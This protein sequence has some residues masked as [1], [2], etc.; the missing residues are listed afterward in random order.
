MTT[1]LTADGL[2]SLLPASVF[3]L[4]I[5][6]ELWLPCREP[7]GR[8]GQRWFGNVGL[9][10]F[11][12]FLALWLL[13]ILVAPAQSRAD[14][15]GVL[16]WLGSLIFLD[17]LSYAS[18]RLLHAVPLLWRLHSVHHTDVDLDATTA[19]RLH[20]LEFVGNFAA[21]SLLA[22]TLGMT[23]EAI[24]V[25]GA[26]ALAIQMVQHANFALPD[27]FDRRL[28]VLLV[29]PGFHRSHHSL[30]PEDGGT[31]FGAVLS[32]WDRLFG[33]WRRLPSAAEV[34]FG[35]PG[36]TASRYQRLD[37]MLLTPLS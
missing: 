6:A 16:G 32:I 7:L 37:W 9:F 29:T 1:W 17:F 27:A 24:T 3:C 35:V 2:V 13:P 14:G 34:R 22:G 26:L 8:R 12:A 19:L 23:A 15:L 10:T 30:A 36:L 33:T 5:A 18:H 21:T 20:P 11:N 28:N 25:Y 31:N 4:M